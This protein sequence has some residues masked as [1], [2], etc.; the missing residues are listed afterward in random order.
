MVRSRLDFH[1]SK[2]LWRISFHFG[3]TLPLTAL[4]LSQQAMAACPAVFPSIMLGATEISNFSSTDFAQARLMG[5][6][7]ARVVAKLTSSQKNGATTT[8]RMKFVN[9]WG[10]SVVAS[11]GNLVVTGTLTFSHSTC[12]GTIST[13]NGELWK[14]N[15]TNDGKAMTIILN[16]W[17]NAVDQTP[18]TGISQYQAP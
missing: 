2:R 1:N 11:G 5:K 7:N 3:M 18:R 17:A 4:L 8:G 6:A 15:V 16:S 13:D 9:D 12:Q 10:S 14:L